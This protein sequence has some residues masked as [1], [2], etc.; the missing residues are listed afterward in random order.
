MHRHF[1]LE[2]SE[3]LVQY[4]HTTAPW[5]VTESPNY[6]QPRITPKNW[7]FISGKLFPYEFRFSP[8]D[9]DAVPYSLPPAFLDD[10]LEVLTRH[11]LQDVYG[12]ARLQAE[13]R[14]T[15]KP[16]LLEFTAGR[17]N[18]VVPFTPD[19][20]KMSKVD[21]SWLFPCGGS[22]IEPKDGSGGLT[23]RFCTLQCRSH[24]DD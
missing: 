20:E 3:Q 24:D 18:I 12:L 11:D 10:V 5:R 2:P 8:S 16:G 6:L 15:T 7:A 22:F 14:D 23:T 9:D 13:D 4:E 21:A 17:T 19:M 1:S